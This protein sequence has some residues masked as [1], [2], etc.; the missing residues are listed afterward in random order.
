MAASRKDIS[1]WFDQGLKHKD[2]FLM[3]VCD[4]YDWEDYPVYAK[5]DKIHEEYARYNGH[6]MQRVMEVYD[7][8]MDKELQMNEKRAFHLPE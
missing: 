7:L 4:T 5:K 6:N 2:D 1:W 3:V 8:H